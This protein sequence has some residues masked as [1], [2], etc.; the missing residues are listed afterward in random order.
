VNR[1]RSDGQTVREFR[2]LQAGS[3]LS[4]NVRAIKSV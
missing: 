1:R 4:L 3:Y 2:F